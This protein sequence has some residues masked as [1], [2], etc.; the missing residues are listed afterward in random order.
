M[1]GLNVAGS[2][3]TFR[4][5]SDQERKELSQLSDELL[6]HDEDNTRRALALM[7]ELDPHLGRRA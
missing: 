2:I 3:R 5:F 1:A 4:K 6:D 7:P